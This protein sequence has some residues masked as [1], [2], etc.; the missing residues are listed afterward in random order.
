MSKSRIAVPL[1]LVVAVLSVLTGPARLALAAG[2]PSGMSVNVVNTPLP[3]Q[4]TVDATVT[5]TPDNPVPVAPPAWQGTPTIATRVVLNHD[6]EGLEECETVFTAAAGTAVVV[7]TVST[8]FNVP[9][10]TFGGARMRV[11]IPGTTTKKAVELPTHPTAPAL[12]VTGNF[13]AYAG[14]LDLGGFPTVAVDFCLAGVSAAGSIAVI[15][16][17][18]PLPN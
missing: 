4:G 6:S 5:N 1:A 7:K 9:P 17:V 11:S 10:G 2:P 3:V 16:F 15:G 18:L 12:Q 13:D 8:S 14:T